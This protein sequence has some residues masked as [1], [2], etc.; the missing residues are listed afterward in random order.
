MN[1][2]SKVLAKF[3]VKSS[4]YLFSFFFQVIHQADIAL[5]ILTRHFFGYYFVPQDLCSF[6]TVKLLLKWR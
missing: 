3:S 2:Q 6:L 5:D 4:G 1:F